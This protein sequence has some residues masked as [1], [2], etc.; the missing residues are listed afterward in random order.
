MPGQ[1]AP[2]GR[3]H[4]AVIGNIGAGKSTAVNAL[5]RELDARVYDEHFDANPYLPS[6][7]GDP[8]RW[9]GLSQLWFLAEVG[10][11][12]LDISERSEVAVQEQSIYTVFAVMTRHLTVHQAISQEDLELVADYF[13]V[14]D[15]LLPTPR[16]LVYLRAPLD[17]LEMRIAARGRGFE[18]S[19]THDFLGSITEALDNFAATWERS[20]VVE[21]DSDA[22]DFRTVPGRETLAQLVRD[23]LAAK[24]AG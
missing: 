19:I 24:A 15:R 16:C 22:I 7:Y 11:Q 1:V 6:F 18:R 17:V 4:V 21:V 13:S 20:P 12:H 2:Q 8:L 3:L 5:G 10:R 14:L 9:A 23:G